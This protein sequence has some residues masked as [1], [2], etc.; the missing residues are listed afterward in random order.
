MNKKIIQINVIARRSCGAATT[1]QPLSYLVPC[2]ALMIL[3]LAFSS[4]VHAGTYIANGHTASGHFAVQSTPDPCAGQ[5][6]G[7][8]CTGGAIYAGTWNTFRYMVT[9]SHCG[10]G[11]PSV[12]TCDGTGDVSPAD[13]MQWAS[14]APASNTQIIASPSIVYGGGQTAT[15]AGTTGSVAALFCKNLTFG[16]YSDWYLP[17]ASLTNDAKGELTNVL[18][19]NRVALTGFV[20]SVYWSSTEGNTTSARGVSFNTG[21][22][23]SFT[24][25]LGNTNVYVRCVRRY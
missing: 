23:S 11:I 3:L 17:A 10:K 18:Y 19:V 16:G 21:G 2:L 6:I 4:P 12:N 24:K 22:P 8:T 15:I 5:P 1:K 13:T 25:T 20:S 14:G 7:G 9:P